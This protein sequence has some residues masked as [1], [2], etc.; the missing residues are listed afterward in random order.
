MTEE[1][2]WYRQIQK[3]GDSLFISIPAEIIR[4][5]GWKKG[6]T[7]SIL[8][9]KLDIK[10]KEKETKSEVLNIIEED[11]FNIENNVKNKSTNEVKNDGNN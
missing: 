3:V 11:K 9:K 5:T 7:L 2:T 1:Y 8:S 4:V 6:D 10:I